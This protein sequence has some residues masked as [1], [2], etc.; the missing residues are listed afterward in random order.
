M[1]IHIFQRKSCTVAVILKVISTLYS[2][3][4][5]C[6]SIDFHD[7]INKYSQ[8]I[9]QTTDYSTCTDYRLQTMNILYR[10][11]TL[12]CTNSRYRYCTVS[13]L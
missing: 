2:N 13:I 7:F 10:L 3:I 4:I 6:I 5:Y 12:C 11:Q 1:F 9:L 8:K